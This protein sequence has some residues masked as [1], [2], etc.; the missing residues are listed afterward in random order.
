MENWS[1]VRTFWLSRKKL[2]LCLLCFGTSMT[3]M[4]MKMFRALLNCSSLKAH[5]FVSPCHFSHRLKPFHNWCTT[6]ATQ[7]LKEL[8]G[9]PL[10][11]WFPSGGS[12]AGQKSA[13]HNVV[14]IVKA[15]VAL[16]NFLNTTDA[17]NPDASDTFC[18]ISQAATLQTETLSQGSRDSM[19]KVTR[20]S[21]RQGRCLQE[22]Q[23][24][25]GLTQGIAWW[26]S[27][28]PL[29]DLCLGKRALS[30][31]VNRTFDNFNV[32]TV[33]NS[34]L[35]YYSRCSLT[36]F[37]HVPS[38]PR[39]CMYSGSVLWINCSLEQCLE[40]SIF[41]KHS[42]KRCITS[43]MKNVHCIY[44]NTATTEKGASLLMYRKV[45]YKYCV[46][47]KTQCTRLYII[48]QKYSEK[49]TKWCKQNKVVH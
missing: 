9:I 42:N 12:S 1:S 27:P 6:T 38:C 31:E 30:E 22:G 45:K 4:L 46:H 48:V 40:N 25:L 29:E 13:T 44:L 43:I 15:G 24:E 10:L 49:Q 47:L 37:Q 39:L 21:L 35:L 5:L 18:H 28:R 32:N 2:F 8:L 17:G 16:H 26:P 23:Q 36:F 3:T 20:T 14:H 41:I 34:L 19:W 7:W 33:I 11:S